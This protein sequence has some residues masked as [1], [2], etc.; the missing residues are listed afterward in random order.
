MFNANLFV[1][2]NRLTAP[3]NSMKRSLAYGVR[4]LHNVRQWLE[5]QKQFVTPYQEVG[6]CMAF[7]EM[8][9]M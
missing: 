1:Y 4:A 8:V 3:S 9:D 7:K 2:Y 6:V 5:E